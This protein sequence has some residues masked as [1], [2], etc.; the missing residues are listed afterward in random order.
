MHALFILNPAAGRQDCTIQL[1]PQIEAAAARAGLTTKQLSILR[2]EHAGHARELA[3]AAARQAEQ[4]GEE[5]RIFTA[6]G[7]GTFNEALAG[8]AGFSHTAVGCLPFGSGNDFL[9]SFGT[10]EEFLDLDAQL[11]GGAAAID[12][13]QTSLGLSAT[14]CAAGLDAQVAYGIPKFRRL[15]FCGGEAAYLLSIVEQVCGHIGRTVR[16]E[17]DGEVLDVDCLMCAVCNGRTYGGGF[18]AAPEARP[19]DGWLDVYIVRT[20]GRLTIARLLGMYKSGKHFV[21]GRLTEQAKPYFIYRRARRVSLRPLDGLGP[22]I[23]TVDGECAPCCSVEVEM[24]PLSGR[25]LLPKPAYERFV[26]DAAAVK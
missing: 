2:T 6:G 25:I 26:R 4:A 13:M 8:A 24:R 10:K 19:D 22:V 1:P 12:L 16:Y 20:V 7:D 3:A 11:G 9:R 17:I 18:I 15:P 14:I 5:L 23:A 21:D